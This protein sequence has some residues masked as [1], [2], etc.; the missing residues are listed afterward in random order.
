MGKKM[1]VKI[2]K[3]IIKHLAN[4]NK[5]LNTIAIAK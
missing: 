2:V 4:N 3:I 1:T 5:Q